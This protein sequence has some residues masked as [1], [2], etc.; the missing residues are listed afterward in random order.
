MCTIAY[1]EPSASAARILASS[2]TNSPTSASCNARLPSAGV[3]SIDL[4]SSDLIMSAVLAGPS[5]ASRP[6]AAVG[7]HRA[8]AERPGGQIDAPLGETDAWS[9]L[10]GDFQLTESSRRR[11]PG[12]VALRPRESAL[13]VL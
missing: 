6:P 8:D 5:A 11:Y 2:G 12:A 3:S 10:G 1:A 9:T 7:N 4:R 13:V